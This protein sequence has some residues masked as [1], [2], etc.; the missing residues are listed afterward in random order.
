M[1]CVCL[2]TISSTP[3]MLLWLPQSCVWQDTFISVTPLVPMTHTTLLSGPPTCMCL[4]AH[5]SASLPAPVL[6]RCVHARSCSSIFVPIQTRGLLV[7]I[8][9]HHMRA[10]AD[11]IL[12]ITALGDGPNVDTR[13][14]LRAHCLSALSRSGAPWR[15]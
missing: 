1:C 6:T 14:V 7:L 5:A 8:Y 4:C 15:Q 13:R 9:L 11:N 12:H 2:Y 3:L 10:P